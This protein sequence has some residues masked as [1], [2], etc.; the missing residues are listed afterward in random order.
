M[1]GKGGLS[2]NRVLIIAF[3]VTFIVLSG[4]VLVVFYLPLIQP[5]RHL[6]STYN[7]TSPDWAKYV[8]TGYEKVTWMNITKVHEVAGNYSIFNS[9]TLL[10]LLGYSND[11][12]VKNCGSSTVVLYQNPNPNTEDVSLNILK[13]DPSYDAA[14]ASELQAKDQ[15]KVVYGGAIIY[16]VTRVTSNSPAYVT[17]YVCLDGGYVLYSDGDKGLSLIE[18]A[19]RSK[20]SG[21]SLVDNQLIKGALYLLA[22]SGDV[23]YSY[24]RL[25][26]SISAVQ[27]V[28]TRVTYEGGKVVTRNVYAFDTTTELNANL[29][30]LKQ[31]N[32]GKDTE[33]VDNYVLTSVSY[34]KSSLL[35][36]LR[37]V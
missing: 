17:G 27:G 2:G 24:S 35:G 4:A 23:A 21:G 15:Q 10:K 14:L 25:P 1:S 28:G 19:L 22:P 36:E 16:Y 13:V 5:A 8:S 33:I 11:I 12:T 31:A 37:S 26:Y 3:A 30:S 7:V 18:A 34:E 29:S 20:V 32:L 6:P 9:D